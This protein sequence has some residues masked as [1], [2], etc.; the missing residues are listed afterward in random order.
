MAWHGMAWHS[1]SLVVVFLPT[2][3]G[4]AIM[5]RLGAFFS[6][7]ALKLGPFCAGPDGLVTFDTPGRVVS[8]AT[9]CESGEKQIWCVLQ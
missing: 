6:V 8:I 7:S 3:G 1:V 2:L 5:V 4:K 9:Q